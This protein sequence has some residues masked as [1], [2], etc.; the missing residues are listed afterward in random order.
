MAILPEQA[1]SWA[2]PQPEMDAEEAS[3]CLVTGLL[4]RFYVSGHL[5][6]MTPAQRHRV[7][8]AIAVAK[9]LRGEIAASHP[10]WPLDLPRWDDP[11][12]ALGLRLPAADLVSIWRRGDEASTALSFPHLVGHDVEVTPVFPL[13]LPSWH[14]EWDATTGTLHVRAGDARISART[15][16]L[17][18]GPVPVDE[19][20]RT[21]SD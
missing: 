15:L 13:D 21:G 11:W 19:G 8:G 1:A 3:F 14:T 17:S 5:N 4:G 6:R 7:A 20:A 12:V 9:E 18:A 10:H 2:Y 16:R